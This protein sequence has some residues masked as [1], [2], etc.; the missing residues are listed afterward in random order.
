MEDKYMETLENIGVHTVDELGRILL[1]R[2]IRETLGWKE[3]DRLAMYKL[4]EE[5]LLLKKDS[6]GVSA[7]AE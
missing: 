1:P 7:K 3:S 6:E 5:T 4:D 2:K